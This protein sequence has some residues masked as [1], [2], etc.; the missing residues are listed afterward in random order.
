MIDL[1]YN[2]KVIASFKH[3]KDVTNF[4]KRGLNNADRYFDVS[5]GL[6]EFM[7]DE[8]L[9]TDAWFAH[10]NTIVQLNNISEDMVNDLFDLGYIYY[11]DYWNYGNS[12]C[13]KF[14]VDVLK[15]HKSIVN[16]KF[17]LRD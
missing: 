2:N 10:V 14:F 1:I 3:Q 16:F 17:L 7:T 9:D 5:E 4:L 6:A 15:N 11:R 12:G 13:T 8:N